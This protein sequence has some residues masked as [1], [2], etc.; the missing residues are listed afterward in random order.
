MTQRDYDT[1]LSLSIT[2][3]PELLWT[4]LRFFHSIT[5]INR[6][7]LKLPCSPTTICLLWQFSKATLLQQWARQS[8]E[9][10]NTCYPQAKW[11]TPWVIL[12]LASKA[13]NV[14]SIDLHCWK[15]S[16]SPA[17]TD[18]DYYSRWLDVSSAWLRGLIRLNFAEGTQS[19][20]FKPHSRW[21][22]IVFG[23]TSRQN[24]FSSCC[25][26][27]TCRV[28]GRISAVLSFVVGNDQ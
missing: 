11:K 19:D 23:V 10:I 24:Y 5:T 14:S 15:T 20:I 28:T 1:I 16:P 6:L 18:A 21:K 26:P 12:F 3:L 25:H 13:H 9:Q 17:P 22:Q 2:I 4:N 27:L 8:A 7:H